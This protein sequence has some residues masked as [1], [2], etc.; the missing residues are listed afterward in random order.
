M[1]SKELMKKLCEIGA[2]KVGEFTVKSG[3]RSPYNVDLRISSSFPDVYEEMG[4]KP[5][6]V[7][8]TLDLSKRIQVHDT[9]GRRNSIN[10]HSRRAIMKRQSAP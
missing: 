5:L 6:A 7:G 8:V 1:P 4:F 9:L 3:K 2:I 10:Q